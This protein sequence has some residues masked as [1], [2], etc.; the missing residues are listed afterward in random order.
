MI[1]R[2]WLHLLPYLRRCMSEKSACDCDGAAIVNPNDH[3][4]AVRQ[5]GHAH[6]GTERQ[7]RM[8]GGEVV[9]A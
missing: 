9:Q 1:T 8:C 3:G 4:P 5:V 7:G 6:V 2:T